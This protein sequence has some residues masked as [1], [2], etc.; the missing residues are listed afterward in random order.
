MVLP[1]L[2]SPLSKMLYVS[3]I[4][5]I[6]SGVMDVHPAAV[7]QVVSDGTLSTTVTTTDTQHFLVE[8]G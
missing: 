1:N 4:G 6:L 5:L 3:S 2:D 7:A 8:G